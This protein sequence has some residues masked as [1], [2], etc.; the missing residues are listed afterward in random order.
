MIIDILKLWKRC[1]HWSFPKVVKGM[2]A[3]KLV[4]YC[5]ISLLECH[6]IANT[7]SLLFITILLWKE[8]HR[9]RH[10]HFCEC[11][12]MKAWLNT[13]SEGLNH[14]RAQLLTTQKSR[15]SF[16]LCVRRA[17][18]T[19]AS[20]QLQENRELVCPQEWSGINNGPW[21]WWCWGS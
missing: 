5:I 20:C 14:E 19:F 16:L 11:H 13:H 1:L 7:L 6:N 3:N 2:N 15:L 12:C 10:L 9:L 8:D 4:F 18:L 21:E 17:P